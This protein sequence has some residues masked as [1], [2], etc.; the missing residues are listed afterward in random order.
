MATVDET[1]HPIAVLIDELKNEYIKLHL[2]SIRRI[3]TIAY[4][5]GEERTRKELIPFLNENND[6]DDEVLLAMEEELGCLSPMWV[7]W[8]MPMFCSRLWKRSALLRKH[9]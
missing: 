6:D 5:L 8:I 9:L 4:A 3:S 2:N 1:L 7:A